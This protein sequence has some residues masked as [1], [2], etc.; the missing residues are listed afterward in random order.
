MMETAKSIEQERL[1]R[2]YNRFPDRDVREAREQ[3]AIH[4]AF[5]IGFTADMMYH[6][7]ENFGKDWPGTYL[8]RHVLVSDWLLSGL[9]K[10]VG[11]GVFE[12]DMQVRGLLLNQLRKIDNGNRIKEVALFVYQYAEGRII[13]PHWKSY[14]D[15]LLLNAMVTFSPAEAQDKIV[16]QLSNIS[17]NQLKSE[18]M[19]YR[20]LL[21]AFTLQDKSPEEIEESAFYPLFQYAVATK[22]AILNVD[23]ALI[24][25]KFSQMQG[26]EGVDILDAPQGSKGYSLPISR[27]VF[28]EEV[29][30]KLPQQDVSGK[31]TVRAFLV[32]IDQYPSES[33]LRPLSGCIKDIN[34]WTNTLQQTQTNEQNKSLDTITLT[35][36]NATLD[37]IRQQ[38]AE[39]VNHSASG[40][41][42]FF[43]FS[44]H[45]ELLEHGE[46]APHNKALFPFDVQMGK[47]GTRNKLGGNFF[48]KHVKANKEVNFVF[49]LDTHCGVQFFEQM[50]ENL[51]VMAACK[52]GEEALEVSGNGL[53]TSAAIAVLKE[54][55][56]QISYDMLIGEIREKIAHTS[57]TQTPT[58]ISSPGNEYKAFLEDNLFT[59]PEVFLRIEECRT[60][61]LK[62]LDLTELNLRY[63]PETIGTLKHLET[64][65]IYNNYISK[66][67]DSI[68]NLVNLKTF[69]ASKNEIDRLPESFSNLTKLQ[70]IR[71]NDNRLSDFPSALRNL[72]DL[73]RI[74]IADNFVDVLPFWV[75]EI[76]NLET[77]NLRNN[78][79][80]N[81]PKGQKKF[82]RAELLALF[83]EMGFSG[84]N[85]STEY[86]TGQPGIL[87]ICPYEE[88]RSIEAALQD[89][90]LHGEL[91]IIVLQQASPPELYTALA[92]FSHRLHLLHMQGWG[93]KNGDFTYCDKNEVHTISKRAFFSF[94]GTIEKPALSVISGNEG[95]FFQEMLDWG[96]QNCV[97]VGRNMPPDRRNQFIYSFYSSLA[98]GRSVDESFSVASN[99]H[100]SEAQTR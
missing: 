1:E 84:K 14:H 92:R 73:E 36:E 52:A 33:N 55:K 99:I 64:L 50:P 12:L 39:V 93:E 32:A 29:I 80:Y 59:N 16:D 58:L 79:V 11:G 46:Q 24:A 8:E 95:T 69:L 51:I 97:T 71:L 87:L 47:S 66:L 89:S 35:N 45:S 82:T 6:L 56:K 94:L 70:E 67:P 30:N 76:S 61:K 90:L 27:T 41:F 21:E 10:S 63:I 98:A 54:N 48:L 91:E 68:G 25:Q 34:D 57:Y 74:E 17:Q 3:L 13:E 18:M 40:D 85:E 49:V 23:P 96:W 43:V 75:T 83:K 22:G 62:Q 5:P 65:D 60:Q 37:G 20:D 19:R 72:P 81:I 44:G 42:V 7:V 28:T 15:T 53:F 77:L 4:A 38:F 86:T 88:Q 26:L 31:K 2:F 78:N 9:C 100:A